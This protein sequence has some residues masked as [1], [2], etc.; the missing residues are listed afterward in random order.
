MLLV[1]LAA[2]A[3]AGGAITVP[4]ADSTPAAEP[5]LIVAMVDGKMRCGAVGLDRNGTLWL[6]AIPFN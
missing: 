5:P 3:L 4:L 6:H 1:T 2:L